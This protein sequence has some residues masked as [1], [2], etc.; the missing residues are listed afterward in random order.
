MKKLVLTMLVVALAIPA[1]AVDIKLVD[2]G[3]GTGTIVYS[4][5]AG[6]KLRGV[7][8]EV[9]LTGGALTAANDVVANLAVNP[10]FN[11]FMDSAWEEET[12]GDGF[13]QED[14]GTGTPLAIA[15]KTDGVN[16]KGPIVSAAGVT[17]FSICMGVLDE[18]GD[19]IKQEAAAEGTDIALIT[20]AVD[21][22][23]D[24]TII[25]DPIR[26]GVAGQEL[27]A[28]TIGGDT[29]ITIGDDA[30]AGDIT[31]V[32]DGMEL[33]PITY[34]PT[35]TGNLDDPD[36]DVDLT[37]LAAVVNILVNEGG[38]G[39]SVTDPAKVAQFATAD[40]TGTADGMELDPITYV[41]TWTGNL[42]A[43]NGA[44]NL[45]DLAAVVNILVNEGGAGYNAV[46]PW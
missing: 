5:A 4:A 19:E 8:L 23:T 44:I 40:V 32:K 3:D 14:I 43:P 37:D 42:D 25:A 31:G 28:L 1:L 7:S 9:T 20:I 29:A 39:Y 11:V 30:C 27:V 16:N 22:A 2:N 38:A 45:T 17:N 46:C 41:P 6:E 15:G 34:V 33:D 13:T 26:G 21:G 18:D 36:G 24:V 35:W 12:N 10:E